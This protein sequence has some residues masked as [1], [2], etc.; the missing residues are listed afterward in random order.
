MCLWPYLWSHIACLLIQGLA[1]LD[2]HGIVWIISHWYA[3]HVWANC[4]LNRQNPE[5]Q[6]LHLQRRGLLCTVQLLCPAIRLRKNWYA[7]IYYRNRINVL[8]VFFYLAAFQVHHRLHAAY[9]SDMCFQARVQLF[10]HQSCNP[11][12]F[13]CRIHCWPPLVLLKSRRLY[14]GQRRFHGIWC[15]C[16]YSL[17]RFSLPAYHYSRVAFALYQVTW[18][19]LSTHMFAAVHT[20]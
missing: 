3:L 11:F 4:L 20:A 13:T 19:F 2:P 1:T 7:F 10:F 15:T 16:L 12:S 8:C 18:I 17:S 5:R 6:N 9:K 14:I